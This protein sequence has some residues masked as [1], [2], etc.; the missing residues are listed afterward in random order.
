M[1]VASS[2]SGAT[3][4]RRGRRD[5]VVRVLVLSTVFPNGCRPTFGV[6]VRERIRHLATR[7]DLQVVA[8]I[9]WFPGQRWIAGRDHR[10]PALEQPGFPVHHP[11]VLSIPGI[12]KALD[13]FF[14]FLSL[15]RF[16]SHLRRRFP[17]DVI[18]AD[19][20]FPDGFG[21]VLLGGAFRCPVV[22][23]L[24]GSEADLAAYALRRPQ[25]CFAVR[26]ARVIAVS[27]S[28]RRLGCDLAG[29]SDRVH[30]IP[31]AVDSARFHPRDQRS[32]RARVGLPEDRTILLGV[33]NFVEGKGHERVLNLLPALLSRRPNLLYVAIGNCGGRDSR[34]RQIREQVRARGLSACVRV[35][36]A[37]PHDEMPYWMAAADLFC[38]AT[39]REGWCNAMMEALACGLPVITTR[40]GGNPEVV[41]DGTDGFLVPFFDSAAFA[42]AISRGF[43]HGWNR[44]AIAQRA[45]ARDWDRVAAEVLSELHLAR[46]AA[47]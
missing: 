15:R 13:G 1:I 47:G 2:S 22:I 42:D 18:A 37:R 3:L 33:G 35:E 10:P 24:R 31:N 27:E 8:P 25:L 29:R 23:T 36:V 6:F 14:Y 43:D 34:L 26:R 30:V 45:S 9:P 28:L 46:A 19:F 5:E 39:R 32:A 17:F 7:C 11:R 44:T 40:V 38:L 4:W 20:G 16:V 41:R 21:A 12:A